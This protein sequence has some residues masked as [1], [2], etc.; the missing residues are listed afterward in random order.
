MC[1][2]PEAVFQIRIQEDKNYLSQKKLRIFYVL[3]KTWV[4]SLEGWRLLLELGSLSRRHR[5]KNLQF[6]KI[7]KLTIFKSLV[8]K[9]LGLDSDPDSLKIY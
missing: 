2:F 6:D 9:Y 8:W 1:N 5:K 4:F 7:C 3:I